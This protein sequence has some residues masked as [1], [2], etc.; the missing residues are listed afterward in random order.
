MKKET[1]IKYFDIVLLS[2]KKDSFFDVYDSLVPKYMNTD[3]KKEKEYFCDLRDEII[4]F[5]VYEKYFNQ[6]PNGSCEL[7][8]KGK[9][10]KKKGGHSKYE[11]Y[12]DKKDLDSNNVN[13]KIDNLISGD[14]YGIQSSK[15]NFNKPINIKT[16]E[17]S[18][19][20]S[21]KESSLK[22][23]FSNPWVI[24]FSFAILAALLS[25]QRIINFINNYI[26]YL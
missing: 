15:T 26:N 8:E 23:V 14:N 13:I 12:I 4:E 3:T 24:G 6:F 2:E 5:A 10:A 20:K 25:A 21:E 18:S 22:K 7:T 16:N 11:G 9:A 19:K 1:V 17:I